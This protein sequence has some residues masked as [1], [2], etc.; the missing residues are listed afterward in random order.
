MEIRYRFRHEKGPIT[1]SIK[2]NNEE[3]NG[4]IGLKKGR[5]DKKGCTDKEG[6]RNISEYKD[7]TQQKGRG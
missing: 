7:R 1:T 4:R 5:K 2:H 6:R 3:P